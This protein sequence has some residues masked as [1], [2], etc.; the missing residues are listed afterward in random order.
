MVSRLFTGEENAEQKCEALIK[1]GEGVIRPTFILTAKLEW[2]PG[3]CPSDPNNFKPSSSHS[4]DERWACL[5]GKIN[6]VQ[7]SDRGEEVHATTRTLMSYTGQKFDD[8]TKEFSLSG[9][10]IQ[11]RS[12]GLP[13]WTKEGSRKAQLPF[14]LSQSQKI[15]AEVF[16]S[17]C[18]CCSTR[19]VA[20]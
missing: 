15:D 8:M 11:G 16:W 12:E 5:R 1:S 14:G 3:R 4:T 17:I 20:S 9:W 18:C 6:A 7:N 19:T 13:F 10:T 2:M